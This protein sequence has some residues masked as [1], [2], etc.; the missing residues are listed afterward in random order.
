MC[1]IGP[2]L[3]CGQP[4][5]LRPPFLLARQQAMLK[6]DA[7]LSEAKNVAAKQA[8]AAAAAA[9][10]KRRE[11]QVRWPAKWKVYREQVRPGELNV[12]CGHVWYV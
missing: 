8:A 6:P 11:R 9:G 10:L 5:A 12:L 3:L 1:P 2:T 7:A 4:S